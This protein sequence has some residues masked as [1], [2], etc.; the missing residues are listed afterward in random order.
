MG[1]FYL[2]W[3]ATHYKTIEINLCNA[4]FHIISHNKSFIST[5][6]SAHLF[7]IRGRVFYIT[8]GTKLSFISQF[9][10]YFLLLDGLSCRIGILSLTRKLVS[11]CINLSQIVNLDFPFFYSP[12]MLANTRGYNFMCLPVATNW[13]TLMPTLMSLPAD[14]ILFC[15]HH[16]RYIETC[17]RKTAVF[18]ITV[19]V[20]HKLL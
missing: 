7:A 11:V 18:S 14:M 8:L 9:L 1:N 16:W 3:F 20:I 13:T 19:Q 4:V 5:S 10:F 17:S 2:T 12:W 15:F 6:S